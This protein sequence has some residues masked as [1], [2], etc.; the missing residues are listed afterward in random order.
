MNIGKI[1]DNTMR[2]HGAHIS[3]HSLHSPHLMDVLEVIEIHFLFFSWSV[4]SSTY[5]YFNDLDNFDVEYRVEYKKDPFM[6]R[7]FNT[8]I[9]ILIFSFFPFFLNFHHVGEFYLIFFVFLFRL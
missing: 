9:F 1:I 2:Y 5:T 4:Y 6:T 8:R 3:Y 7:C